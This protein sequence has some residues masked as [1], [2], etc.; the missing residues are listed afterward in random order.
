MDSK[1]LEYTAATIY[2]KK[3]GIIVVVPIHGNEEIGIGLL[4]KILKQ[5]GISISDLFE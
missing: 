2:L 4:H 5:A 3:D 1:K